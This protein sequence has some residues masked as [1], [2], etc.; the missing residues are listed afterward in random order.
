MFKARSFRKLGIQLHTLKAND[1]PL[2]HKH[3]SLQLIHTNSGFLGADTKA[4]H[5]SNRSYTLHDQVK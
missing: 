5:Q 3:A 4:E 1:K 2:L